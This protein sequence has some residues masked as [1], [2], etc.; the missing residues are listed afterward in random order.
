[1]QGGI[2]LLQT[3][4]KL[5]LGLSWFFKLHLFLGQGW[6]GGCQY[7]KTQHY[8]ADTDVI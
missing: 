7:H 8:D 3:C 2:K 5:Y 1:M 4:I 6:G